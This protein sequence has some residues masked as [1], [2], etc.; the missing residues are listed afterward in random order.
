MSDLVRFQNI[1]LSLAVRQDDYNHFDPVTSSNFG[2]I[3]HFS[4]TSNLKLAYG[5][6]FR[7]PSWI[8]YNSHPTIEKVGN[9]DLK[10]EQIETTELFWTYIPTPDHRVRVGGFYSKMTDVI[11]STVDPS[12]VD[13]SYYPQLIALPIFDR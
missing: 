5:N 2:L 11:D 8:E 4:S 10:P 12:D 9:K 7:V 3:Y 13:N 1:D 6:A